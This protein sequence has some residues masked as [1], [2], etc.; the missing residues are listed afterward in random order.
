MMKGSESGGKGNIYLQEIG[1][2]KDKAAKG[3]RVQ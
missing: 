1:G 2:R 3:R